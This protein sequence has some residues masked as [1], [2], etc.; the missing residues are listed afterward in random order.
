MIETLLH[1]KHNPAADTLL[2]HTHDPVTDTRHTAYTTLWLSNPIDTL[3][4]H[5]QDS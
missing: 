2:H 5:K 1:H 4:R 3:S